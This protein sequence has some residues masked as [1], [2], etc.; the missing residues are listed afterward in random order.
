MHV[1]ILLLAVPIH[2]VAARIIEHEQLVV[3]LLLRTVRA[4][5][6]HGVVAVVR[7]AATQ[8]AAIPVKQACA[9]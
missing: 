9:R 8:P 7:A 2:V 1:V 6:A 3:Q 5:A 4:G